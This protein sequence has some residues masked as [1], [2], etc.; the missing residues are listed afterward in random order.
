[1]GGPKSE[2]SR[3]EQK[4]LQTD[5]IVLVPGPPEAI[6][7]VRWMYRTFVEERKSEREIA[8]LLNARSHPQRSR[9][10]LD[11]RLGPSGPDQR[12]IHRQQCVESFVIQAEDEASAQRP[13]YMDPVAGFQILQGWFAVVVQPGRRFSIGVRQ[14]LLLGTKAHSGPFVQPG[15]QSAK[16]GRRVARPSQSA[17]KGRGNQGF[18]SVALSYRCAVEAAAKAGVVAGGLR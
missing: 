17:Q 16:K 11:A 12:K 8:D 1:L 5:R 9:P 4:S 3:G 13:E 2:L 18:E 15:S 6:E 14:S 10:S 7:T